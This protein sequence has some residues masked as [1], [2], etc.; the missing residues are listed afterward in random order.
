MTEEQKQIIQDII[1]TDY[2][3]D[4][5]SDNLMQ[6]IWLMSFDRKAIISLYWYNDK[7]KEINFANLDVCESIRKK[8]IGTKILKL[9]EHI[10]YV[11]KMQIMFLWVE[12][13]T[14]Q[15][16]WY[17]RLGYTYNSKHTVEINNVWLQKI[18]E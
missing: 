9:A 11:L 17:K 6:T 16:F 8:G 3:A 10:S 15:Y 12:E 7:P 13:F 5:Q 14:F 18:I 2:I 1:G 4:F